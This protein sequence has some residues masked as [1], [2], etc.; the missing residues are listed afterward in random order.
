MTGRTHQIR[1]HLQWL[2]FPIANDPL[3]QIPAHEG[4]SMIATMSK[5]DEAE[6]T[7]K[8]ADLSEPQIGEPACND[9]ASHPTD[10]KIDVSQDDECED[11]RSLHLRHGDPAPHEL[12]I[13]L[14]AMR[15]YGEGWDY[16]TGIFDWRVSILQGHF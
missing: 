4:R 1:V 10:V 9:Q 11:C 12:Y 6:Y 3:Y 5:E 7:Q 13:W 15:Y 8:E 14:H 2:G 16:Q